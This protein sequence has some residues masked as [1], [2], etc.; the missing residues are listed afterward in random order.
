MKKLIILIFTLSLIS[1]GS[2]K[3]N[4]QSSETKT[5]SLS[6]TNSSSNLNR[7]IDSDKYSLEPADLTQPM[8]FVNSKGEVKEYFNTKI[9][10]DKTIIH[11]QQ[12][13]TTAKKTEL[14]KE[15]DEKSSS[16]ERDN[17]MVIL[18]SFAIF[19]VFLLIVIIFLAWWFGKK[20]NTMMQLLPK[21]S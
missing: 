14:K 1:C 21:N 19:L 6:E 9:I 13:D 4:R 5:D 18:G 2:V 15:V 10:H 11:E 3:K 8:R 20:I 7:W 17:T 12:K 16:K